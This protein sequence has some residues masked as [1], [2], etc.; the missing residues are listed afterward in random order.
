MD[1]V[2]APTAVNPTA[3]IANGAGGIDY[4]VGT[5]GF[6]DAL[7]FRYGA[8]DCFTSQNTLS[9]FVDAFWAKYRSLDRH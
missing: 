5:R 8:T 1:H 3:T 6:P 7:C 9:D 4:V 2:I